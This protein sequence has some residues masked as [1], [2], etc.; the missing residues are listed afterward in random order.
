MAKSK[1]SIETYWSPTP[2]KPGGETQHTLKQ[3]CILQELRTLQKFQQLKPQDNQESRDKCSCNF[4]WTDLTWDR[5]ARQAFD[6]LLF[7]I[8]NSLAGQKFDID[9]DKDFKTK[10]TPSDESPAYSQNLPR[11]TNLKVNIAVE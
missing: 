10:L 5:S 2:L 9:I 8:H 11:R 4:N 7:Q 1:E 6:E 3:N